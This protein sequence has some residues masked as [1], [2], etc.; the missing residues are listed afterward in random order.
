[1]KDLPKADERRI[2]TTL[3]QAVKLAAAGS[4][5]NDAIVKAAGDVKLPMQA[6]QRIC[7]AFN[8]SKTLSHFKKTAG[9]ARAESFPIVDT[10]VVLQ[11]LWPAKPETPVTKNFPTSATGI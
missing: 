1:M 10:A 7:E 8:T 2:V 4:T 6:V 5:P 9:T 3:E 11:T